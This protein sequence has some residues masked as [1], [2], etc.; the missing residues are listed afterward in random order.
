[1]TRFVVVVLLLLSILA[2]SV[3]ATD[4][5]WKD[6]VLKKLHD[7]SVVGDDGATRDEILQKRVNR[8]RQLQ[9]MV[10]HMRQ[11]L[12]DHS[13]GET[14]LDPE[15]K[16]DI[17]KKMDIFQ[18]KISTMKGEMDERVSFSLKMDCAYFLLAFRLLTQLSTL[19]DYCIGY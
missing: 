12:A 10:N 18:R 17:E 2:C 15:E 6:P 5:E 9:N 16:V 3:T 13:A 7:E 14:I 19:F 11:Q 4:R 8:R 1:M